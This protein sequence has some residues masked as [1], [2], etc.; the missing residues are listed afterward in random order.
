MRSVVAAVAA[1]VPLYRLTAFRL[2]LLFLARRYCSL[3]G[4]TR[5]G[6]GDLDSA[7]EL[8]YD[9]WQAHPI[10]A[11]FGAQRLPATTSNEV[12]D[13]YAG[14][15][16]VISRP[17][18]PYSSFVDP[19]DRPEQD[20]SRPQLGTLLTV[21]DTSTNE[22]G[23]SMMQL[24]NRHRS[25]EASQKAALMEQMVVVTHRKSFDHGQT[26]TGTMKAV[27]A[28]QAERTTGQIG[29]AT[30]NQTLAEIAHTDL[31]TAGANKKLVPGGRQEIVDTGSKKVDDSQTVPSLSRAQKGVNSTEGDVDP[32]QVAVDTGR[33]FLVWDPSH[34]VE[35]PGQG[36]VA[37]VRKFAS[38]DGK[39]V[40]T[41]ENA[42]VMG[43]AT[44]DA[45]RN[46][47]VVNQVSTNTRE[48]VLDNGSKIAGSDQNLEDSRGQ[49]SDAIRQSA[50]TG[51]KAAAAYRDTVG[52]DSKEG[53]AER[54]TV[55]IAQNIPANSPTAV[56]TPDDTLPGS[57]VMLSTTLPYV[58][59]PPELETEENMRRKSNP[60]IKRLIDQNPHLKETK[61]EP[62]NINWQGKDFAGLFDA[63][64][65]TVIRIQAI[66][67]DANWFQPYARPSDME[68]IGSGWMVAAGNVHEKE[69]VFLTNAHV[70]R[71]AEVVQVQLPGLGQT[72]FDAYVPLICDEFDLAVVQLKQP[73]LF[74]EG[75][76]ESSVTA[77]PLVVMDTPLILGLEVASVG[78]PLGSSSLKLSRGVISGTEE[79]GGTM[80]YQ[81]TAP[82]S[83]G[84]SG[85]PLFALR[86]DNEKRTSLQVIGA[87][88]ASSSSEGSQN[89]NYVVPAVSITQVINE[90]VDQRCKQ[91][92]KANLREGEDD[93]VDAKPQLPKLAEHERDQIKN[94]SMQLHP[95]LAASQPRKR[96]HQASQQRQPLEELFRVQMQHRLGEYPHVQ[97]RLAPV[98]AVGIEGN[99]ALYNT[100]G[101]CTRG[102]FLSKIFNTSV[103]NYARP[104]V[105]ERSFLVK[106]D[107][108]P[109]DSFG[110][111][112]T[113]H[114][115]GDPTPFESLMMLRPRVDEP[116]KLTVCKDGTESV[117]E[118]FMRWNDEHHCSGV[119]DIAEPIFE[120]QAIDFEAFAGVTLMQMTVNHIV[121]LLR[122]S[123]IP[124]SV[125][126]WLL[127]E[128]EQSPRVL[129]TYVDKGM[130]ASRVL[131]PG[132]VLSKVNGQ[133]ISTLQD[134][135]DSFVPRGVTW[136]LETDRGVLFAV[137]FLDALVDQL[138]RI[139]NG[140]RYLMTPAIANI[141]E[142]PSSSPLGNLSH[143]L[144]QNNSVV[145]PDLAQARF[146][147][148]RTSHEEMSFRRWPPTDRVTYR[149]AH[150]D[151]APASEVSS[152]VAIAAE[153][154]AREAKAQALAQS[155]V[156]FQEDEVRAMEAQRRA[157][158]ARAG[159][160]VQK[161]GAS[162]DGDEMF[163]V[164]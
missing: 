68:L 121:K 35:H 152:R 95:A 16:T 36:A 58:P 157:R 148:N 133:P 20:M 112:Y 25:D 1:A 48:K 18:L 85:G 164:L 17:Y 41:S 126:R 103:L 82:I 145:I 64:K 129:I 77:N 131:A 80:R 153:R 69:P 6:T 150:W 117:H 154:I 124:M 45:S 44:V 54:Q 3:V 72:F 119:K 66:S 2:A 65:F 14:V 63:M 139:Q 125:G 108:T 106:V 146:R 120:Q 4:A 62:G 57:Q 30:G 52:T 67:S 102:V 161:A 79:V 70:V 27:E 43:H 75:L 28:G 101:G 111:G 21:L 12:D 115:L 24:D 19:Q 59:V 162:L 71:N 87:T 94:G 37:S 29:I 136:T 5:P 83:P 107:N 53:V 97:F 128:N 123:S 47:A 98:D 11:T 163:S 26:H 135:R 118:A 160:I 99:E 92:F 15:S 73:K 110:M 13:L 34:V 109:L 141:L 8:R 151:G 158:A 132:M 156:A 134:V 100:S 159:F 147:W 56:G 155:A 22:I 38:K 130:Y 7:R 122:S 10:A 23:A 32:K 78:F 46:V 96:D 74:V 140:L 144:A 84:S 61:M 89:I 127:P 86:E 60:L 105:P 51:Q 81:T 113:E 142:A 50:N 149:S 31:N 91:D 93:G 143:S 138:I 88:F 40:H 114:F 76:R 9:G 90:F 49:V 39:T 137:K 104:I 116:V 33:E 55:E 42:A